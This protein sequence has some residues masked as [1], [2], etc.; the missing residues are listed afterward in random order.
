MAR[1]FLGKLGR[2][3]ELPEAVADAYRSLLE[4]E[5]RIAARDE[6][7]YRKARRKARKLLKRGVN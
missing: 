2:G 5:E 4:R 3:P 7:K 6:A 1:V